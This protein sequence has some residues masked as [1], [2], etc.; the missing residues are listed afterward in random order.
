MNREA[1]LGHFYKMRKVKITTYCNAKGKRDS[2]IALLKKGEFPFVLD[3]TTSDGLYFVH[4][5]Y[6]EVEYDEER[7]RQHMAK[8]FADFAGSMLELNN[9]QVEFEEDEDFLGKI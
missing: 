2:I 6:F 4:H 3:E 5:L 8:A 9:I 7:I 1:F